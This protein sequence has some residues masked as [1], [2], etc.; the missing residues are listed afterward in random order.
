MD[1][2]PWRECR[3]ELKVIRDRVR[4]RDI[5]RRME[6]R[7]R[8]LE[9]TRPIEIVRRADRPRVTEQL[10]RIWDDRRF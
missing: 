6:I 9:H 5:T 1:D 7:E 4:V 10:G 8:R 2:R 3:K